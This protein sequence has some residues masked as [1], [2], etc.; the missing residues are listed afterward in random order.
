M[1]VER[2]TGLLDEKKTTIIR[3]FEHFGIIEPKK[4]DKSR[5]NRS[6]EAF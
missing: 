3:V 4:G 6:W 1:A 5:F 2:R